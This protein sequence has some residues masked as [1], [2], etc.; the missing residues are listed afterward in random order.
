MKYLYGAS[1]HGK[2]IFDILHYRGEEE[3]IF[4]DDNDSIHEFVNKKV[5][6]SINIDSKIPIIISIGN[7]FIRKRISEKL[8]NPFLNAI[9]L[10]ANISEFT[11]IGKG[12]AI[13]AGA[14]IN[15]DSKIGNHCIINTNA[16]IDHDCIIEDFV[17]ISPNA[18]L[19]GNV[20]VGEGTWIGAGATII[21]GIKIGKW[22]TVG[23]GSVVLENIPDYA[24]AVGVPAKIIK[25]NDKK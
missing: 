3:I 4:V 22:V 16:S 2:V 14:A 25:Y 18:T 21:Q 8:T 5:I 24:V 23:A 13:M 20:Q 10:S 19:A 17:H 15:I 7:N 6:K 12:I 1:G 11:Q 9:H